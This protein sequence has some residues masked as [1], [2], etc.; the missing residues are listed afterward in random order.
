LNEIKRFDMP[1]FVPPWPYIREMVRYGILPEDHDV[2]Q[3][4]DTYELD[5][6]YWK[7]LWYRP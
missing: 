2:A 5:R 4:V 7:S 3:V 6:A 1:G